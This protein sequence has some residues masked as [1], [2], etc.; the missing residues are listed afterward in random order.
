M[1]TLDLLLVLSIV[2]S[3]WILLFFLLKGNNNGNSKE[4]ELLQKQIFE[5]T[6]VLEL[7]MSE[8]N[9]HLTEN[10]QKTFETSSK[11]SENANKQIEEISK[12]LT[13]LWETNKQI[14]DIWGQL[15]GLEKILKNPKQRGILWEYFLE[16]VLKNIFAPESYKLQYPFKNGEIVDAVIFIKEKLIPIDSKFSLENYSKI[17]ESQSDEERAKYE[18]D[19]KNDLKKRIDETSKYIRP[20][21]GTM[22]FAFMFIPSEAIY[23]DLLINKVGALKINTSDL[24]EYAFKEKKVIIVSPTSFYA[25][26]QT[27]LQWLKAMQIEEAAKDI[28]KQVSILANHLWA[29][30]EYLGKVWN[31]LSTTVN[32]YNKAY[33][34]FG[35]I[36][37]DVIKITSWESGGNIKVLEIEN[38]EQAK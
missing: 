36:D 33:K 31:S 6:R 11:I 1:D 18:K 16:T 30:E 4:T 23:Y 21:E 34:E 19:F 22:D 37:K 7:K 20:D 32:H 15:E 25:Y 9:K 26:L 12:R 38:P 24:I 17:L 3:F 2:V 35:K 13:E 14:K 28:Q 8:S 27:V 10:M 29:Y 5:L